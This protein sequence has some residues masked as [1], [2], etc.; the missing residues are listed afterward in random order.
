[1][2]SELTHTQVK[3]VLLGSVVIVCS[4]DQAFFYSRYQKTLLVILGIK[5]ACAFSIFT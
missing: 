1:M 2:A 3:F 4:S 5:V